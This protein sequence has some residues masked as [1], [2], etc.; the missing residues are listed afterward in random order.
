MSTSTENASGSAPNKR[1]FAHVRLDDIVEF[2]YN[3][4][5]DFGGESLED[6]AESIRVQ[7]VIEPIILHTEDCPIPTYIGI[8]GERRC[9]A[10]RVAGLEEVPA[11]VF[12]GI[13]KA[14]AV[15][16][17]LVENLQR[18]DVN[19]IEEAYGYAMLRDLGGLKQAEIAQRVGR[20]RATV[21]NSLRLLQLPESVQQ[22]IR[23]GKLTRTHGGILLRFKDYPDVVEAM[24]EIAVKDEVSAGEMSEHAFPFADEVTRRTG[25][26]VYRWGSWE[27]RWQ[28]GLKD[29]IAEVFGA[30]PKGWYYT[31]EA[32]PAER[33]YWC[34]DEEAGELVYR[35]Q[36]RNETR[37][38]EE[39]EREREEA[40]ERLEEKEDEISE[41]E[42]E[43]REKLE[44]K[45]QANELRLKGL[46]ARYRNFLEDFL[47]PKGP[48][49]ASRL[50]EWEG[51]IKAILYDLIDD[52]LLFYDDKELMEEYFGPEG[53]P[54]T[55]EA[56]VT[57][58]M[59]LPVQQILELF[60]R[61]HALAR[62]ISYSDYRYFRYL[63]LLEGKGTEHW[64]DDNE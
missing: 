46:Q 56:Q 13:G 22:H 37:I 62:D 59:S 35:L 42:R 28:Q 19:A 9:R 41:E 33:N 52:Y 8:A 21:A 53:W 47:G 25:R 23:E 15:E 43:L 51:I 64:E 32:D 5:A 20:P 39:E 60:L 17:A 4:R 50:V 18:K 40:D 58:V 26:T 6:L 44:E 1:Y 54:E 55:D 48:T 34:L 12:S 57:A 2:P 3:Y 31:D 7:G 16:M 27:L 29:A 36:K 63:D 30:D 45:R 10:A 11:I 61:K 49:G 24:A 38:A 14:E